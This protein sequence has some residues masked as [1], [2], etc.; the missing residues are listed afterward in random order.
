MGL[1]LVVAVHVIAFVPT[2]ASII[3][4]II[5]DD[6]AVVVVVVVLVVIFVVI[7]A[8]IDV[9]VVGVDAACLELGGNSGNLA[10]L[11]NDIVLLPTV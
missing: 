8:V 4:V 3:G 9:A 1:V 5:I 6:I 2:A 10:L 11:D 7:I